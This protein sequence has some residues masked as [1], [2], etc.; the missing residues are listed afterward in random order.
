MSHEIFQG[1]VH[2]FADFFFALYLFPGLVV[3]LDAASLLLGQR[4]RW[5]PNSAELLFTR[6]HDH[7]TL[8]SSRLGTKLF[9]LLLLETDLAPRL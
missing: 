5:G 3:S 4:L 1:D 2:F 6:R 9:R 7:R 8:V